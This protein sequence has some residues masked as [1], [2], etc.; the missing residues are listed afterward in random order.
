MWQVNVSLAYGAKGI[1]YFT[2]WTPEV[3][4]DAWRHFGE[5][6][7]SADWQPTPLYDYA[8]RVNQYLKVVG[9]V[10]LPLTTE[11][12]VHAGEKPLPRGAKAFKADGGHVSSTSGSPVILSRFRKPTGG[13]KRY[14]FVANRSFINKTETRLT[15]Y[16]SVSEV[17]ELDSQTGTFARVTQQGTLLVRLTPGGARLYLLRSI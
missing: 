1:Q 17:L 8:K 3:A 10:L 7:V 9:K 2:Y 12:V 13:T 6:L 15:L 4:S 11:A 14:L 5:A 16:D